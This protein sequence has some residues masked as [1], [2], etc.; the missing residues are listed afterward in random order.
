MSS[1]KAPAAPDYSPMINAARANAA[2]DEQISNENLAWAR[3]YLSKNQ[4][5]AGKVTDNLLNISK[6]NQ[7]NSEEDRQR[8]K[9]VFQPQEDALVNDANTYASQAKK[10]QVVGASQANVGQAFDAARDSSTRQLE[11]FGLNPADT[12]MRALDIGTRAQEAAAKASAGN[13]ASNQVDQTARDLRTQAI[14]L[15]QQTNQNATTEAG[16]AQTAGL[17]AVSAGNSTLTSG[18]T[19]IGAPTTWDANGNAALTGAVGAQN[20]G[21]QNSLDQ[22]KANQTSSSGIGSLIGGIAGLSKNSISGSALSG[23]GGFL[24]AADGGAVPTDASPSQGGAID[25]VDAKLTAGEF[26]VPKDVVA[27]L[28]EEKLQ[29]II[30]QARK[31]RGSGT[32]AAPTQRPAV[33]G[34]PTFRSS[35]AQQQ[36]A[37]A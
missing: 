34:P 21:Y 14:G 11:S 6:Q 29:K 16:T 37:V 26:V 32:E 12:R 7:Q 36:G 8:Y 30:M 1:N 20:A 24:F 17:G 23:L 25:D 9:D 28:G 35:G 31:A 15:G 33:G 4:D 3:D 10:D 27:W 22:F 19:A 18:T 2:N 5:T 13:I